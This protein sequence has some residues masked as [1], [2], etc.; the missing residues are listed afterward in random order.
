MYVGQRTYFDFKGKGNTIDGLVTLS[1][2]DMEPNCKVRLCM[3][4]TM[5]MDG[6]GLLIILCLDDIEPN[7]KVFPLMEHR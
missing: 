6:Y 5:D 7:C 3:D 2:D 1:L 4:K